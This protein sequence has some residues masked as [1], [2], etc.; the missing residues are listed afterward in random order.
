MGTKRNPG[1]F[2]CY[3][4]AEVDEPRF[5]LLGRDK[6]APALIREWAFLRRAQI[7]AGQKPPEDEDKVLE[8][9]ACAAAMEAWRRQHR[10]RG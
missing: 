7:A 9:L 1:Q 5:V 3:D 10:G 6:A 2:D 8:A 4:A